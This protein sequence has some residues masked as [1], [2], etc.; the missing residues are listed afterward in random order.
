MIVCVG[1]NV[2][3]HR[4]LDTVRLGTVMLGKSETRSKWQMVNETT[5]SHAYEQHKQKPARLRHTVFKISL[6]AIYQRPCLSKFVEKSYDVRPKCCR[7]TVSLR[8]SLVRPTLEGAEVLRKTLISKTG[9]R[10]WRD[11][12]DFASLLQQS[13]REDMQISCTRNPGVSKCFPFPVLAC[14]HMTEPR[15]WG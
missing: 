14:N 5:S 4:H 9:A 7:D 8:L 11:Y 10:N 12:G 13:K 1:A 3:I 2:I 6:S 15:F